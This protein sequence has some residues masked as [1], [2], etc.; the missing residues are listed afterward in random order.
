[1]V[2]DENTAGWSRNL[3]EPAD[4]VPLRGVVE[5]GGAFQ[6]RKN[7]TNKAIL[8]IFMEAT[9]HQKGFNIHAAIEPMPSI[10]R[11]T[12]LEQSPYFCRATG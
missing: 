10:S 3:R 12:R 11:A 1:M 8:L 2:G 4:F 5:F 7:G 9:S 6:S